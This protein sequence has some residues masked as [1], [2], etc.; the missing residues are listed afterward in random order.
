MCKPDVAVELKV[1]LAHVGEFGGI[2]ITAKIKAELIKHIRPGGVLVYN[3]DDSYCSAMA[4]G[5]DGRKLSFGTGHA[6]YQA[7]GHRLSLDGTSAEINY[8]DGEAAKLQLQI[9]GEHQV[10]NALATMRSMSRILCSISSLVKS[11]L[12]EIIAAEVVL[13][14]VKKKL[15]DLR[16]ELFPRSLDRISGRRGELFVVCLSI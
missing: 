7:S 3:S 8:P 14:R 11:R 12:A 9:L 5:F 6:D 4:D 15:K 1:G 2:E 16:H 10:M 13:A